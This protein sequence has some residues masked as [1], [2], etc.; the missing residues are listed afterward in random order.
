MIVRKVRAAGTKAHAKIGL[1]VGEEKEYKAR[2]LK[3]AKVAVKKGFAEITLVGGTKD[4]QEISTNEV[5]LIES[6][7]PEEELVK[8][9][10]EGSIDAVVRGSIKAS[11]ILKEIKR[12]L[13]PP[14]IFRVALLSTIRNHDFFF[15]P[16]GIDEG[17]NTEEKLM[18]ISAGLKLI[19]GLGLKPKI[20][21]LSGGRRED[22][23]RWQSVNETIEEA[24][25]V[26]KE[27]RKLE[28]TDVENYEILIE[29]AVKEGANLIIAPNGI[30]GNLIYRTLI[31]LG[32]GK[33]HGAPLYGIKYFYVDT[34]RVGPLTE[35]V[36]AIALASAIT[37]LKSWSV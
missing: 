19:E 29:K 25:N 10:K 27:I 28:I 36:D 6:S 21:V 11:N 14:R 23:Y 7:K 33:S 31:H 3:A 22:T 34:S 1:G 24:D 2:T 26:V 13:K 37:R 5:E 32:G 30:A 15:A 35:Y 17:K 12:Q 18:L 16:V 8:M 20:A 9:L 4:L